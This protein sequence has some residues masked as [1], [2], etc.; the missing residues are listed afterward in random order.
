[1]TTS[2]RRRLGILFVV[3]SLALLVIVVLGAMS[4]VR[5]ASA[6][7]E[8]VERIQVA[9]IASLDLQVSLFDQQAA[10][11]GYALT[12]DTELLTELATARDVERDTAAVLS[13]ELG[14]DALVMERL[15][16][17]IERAESWRTTL[18]E[19]AIAAASDGR[20]D[21]AVAALT[22]PSA[23]AFDEVRQ[24][25][26]QLG[27]VMGQ[28]RAEAV[29]GI[30]RAVRLL[31]YVAALTLGLVIAVAATIAVALR[32]D[33]LRPL[34]MLASEARTVAGGDFDH[35]VPEHGPS[36][37]RNVARDVEAMRWQILLELQQ[38]E[39]ARGE[40]EQ[41]AADLHRSNRDL[42]QFAYVASHDLQEPLR[43]VAGF[44][45]LLERRYGDELDDRAREYIHYAVDG[46]Q[47][48]Q[49]LINDL[50]TFSRVGR[51]TE[52][53]ERVDLGAVLAEA[54]RDTSGTD[55]AELEAS[56]LPTVAGD[57]ALLRT[58]FAN[59]VS[60]SIKFRSDAPPKIRVS[61]QQVDE[62]W[63]IV[64]QDNGI[65]IDEQFGDRIFDIFQRLHTREVYDGT[66]IGLAISK[67]IVEFHGG[68]IRLAPS[69]D[70][71]CFVVRL[72]VLDQR[73]PVDAPPQPLIPF[74]PGG[75]TP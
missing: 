11:R 23:T 2:L 49:T 51:T 8:L 47:R 17:L 7:T 37:I 61:A 73:A 43:K 36:E 6:R 16:A 18:A 59:L 56:D 69:A 67:R 21:D 25:G 26:V 10:V 57:P 30:D 53:F 34:E 41:H 65:G 64:V 19:P 32:R 48:M 29:A 22:D 71:A 63:D 74:R 3:A 38:T 54:W 33:V 55:T 45:Q 44:C 70:G 9:R 72:P 35:P 42:E 12:G 50:L 28:R 58:L 68:N 4:I 40:S 75:A 60:N 66:G 15:G 39:Q 1:M 52:R 62:A 13:A 5:L 31:I 14:G 46:A 24:A 27:E 20:P